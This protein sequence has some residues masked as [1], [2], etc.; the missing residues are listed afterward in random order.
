M[1]LIKSTFLV[2]CT[3][4]LQ[5]S[6]GFAQCAKFEPP[7]GKAL[8][9]VGQDLDAVG[10]LSSRKNGYV[11]NVVGTTTAIFPGGVTTYTDLTY[12]LGLYNETDYGAGPLRAQSYIED[13]D[14]N[15]T[16]ISIGLD[17]QS[18]QLDQAANGQLDGNINN[19]IYWINTKNPRPIFLRIGYEFNATHN[20]Y[21]GITF[22][23]AWKRIVD[24]FRAANVTNVAFVWQADDSG[25][26]EGPLAAW[27][28]GD[29]YVDWVAF[30]RFLGNGGGMISFARTHKKPCMIAEATPQ[31]HKT[32]SEDG[33]SLWNNWYS[34]LFS[35]IHSN[36]DVIKAL[37]YINQN[38]DA[39]Q[40]WQGTFGDSR[41]QANATLKTKWIAEV[42]TSFWLH[43]SST[44]FSTL[45]NGCSG[46]ITADFVSNT[47]RVYSGRSLTFTSH[48]SGNITGYS[49]DFGAG[50]TPATSTSSAPVS[51]SYS[52]T[53]LKTVK[54][55]VTGPGGLSNVI[56]K[57]SY[58]TVE[59][60][61]SSSCMLLDD[62]NSSS[63]VGKF[64]SPP[65]AYTHAQSGSDW[66]ISSPAGQGEW[67]F[68]TYKF[69]D[70]SNAKS[71]N[72]SHPTL[73]KAIVTLR[74]KKKAAGV[75]NADALLKIDLYDQVSST[76]GS[77][78]NKIVLTESYQ[79][80]KIDF[81]NFLVNKYGCALAGCGP[82][83]L[84][85]II[86][87]QF[88]VNPGFVSYPITFNSKTF[89]KAF[90]GDILIDV[91]S[92]GDGCDNI[93][94]ADFTANTLSVDKNQNV[95]FSNASSGTISAYAWNFGAGA[96]PAIATGVGPH[97]VKYSSYGLKTVSL[98]I[99]GGSSND[100]KTRT[101]YINVIAKSASCG[102]YSDQFDNNKVSSFVTSNSSGVFTLA[103]AAN[104]MTI[105]STGHGEFDHIEI[106]ANDGVIAS[107]V[108]MT[109]AQTLEIKIKAS[110]AMGV[111]ISLIDINDIEAGNNNLPAIFDKQIT[112]SWQTF[113]IDYTGKLVG[114]WFSK[115]N[116]DVTKISKITLRPNPAFASNPIFGYTSAFKGTIDVEFV[117]LGDSTGCANVWTG[118]EEVQQTNMHSVFP[119]PFS[120][121]TSI[122]IDGNNNTPTHLVI[123]DLSGR[124]VFNE[125]VK[126][127][128]AKITFGQ[129]LQSGMYLV[130]ITQNNEVQTMKIV[131]Q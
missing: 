65:N 31:G 59:A 23:K 121:E 21:N 118:V 111:R 61:P 74:V 39:Q 29:N 42:N 35:Q 95:I 113:K 126:I 96:I 75:S 45:Q 86:G 20:N 25:M 110:S 73:T 49:W 3:L 119:N 128:N 114:T 112:T 18:G 85:N 92:F 106:Q 28:P 19:L 127:E 8:L 30:S 62:F 94:L 24:M 81:T 109:T 50:A 17:L 87:A 5:I 103:E 108:D 131:K 64:A 46:S 122:T 125:N 44:L 54:L 2:V 82:V 4:L 52:S 43:A 69:N 76:D 130:Q 98:T 129:N 47:Q 32:A 10:G 63:T 123:Y 56:T 102:L 7:S 9:I 100:T 1:K 6:T 77:F 34:P 12:N 41:I 38:W 68:F 91:I 70:G 107:P 104:V 58:I 33:N 53:G 84:Y 99:S 115:G 48:S 11:E 55:T 72:F 15:N 93:V 37:C 16:V 116:L 79:T 120:T 71:F 26:A 14:F 22:I 67:D 124:E 78:S 101:D 40:I 88:S 51:V 105:T 80:I 57:A 66:V 83:D 117:I 60:V 97:T 36:N 27:Y 90:K 89:N 13:A